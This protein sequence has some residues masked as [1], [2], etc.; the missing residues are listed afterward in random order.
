M[1]EW[2][3][4]DLKEEKL[5]QEAESL[6]VCIFVFPYQLLLGSM[7]VRRLGLSTLNDSPS[8]SRGL[9]TN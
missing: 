5:I 2:C 6:S 9:R 3:Q 4:T 8:S 1:K 7:W